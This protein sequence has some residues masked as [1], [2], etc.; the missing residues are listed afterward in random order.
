MHALIHYFVCTGDDCAVDCSILG[1]LATTFTTL[2]NTYILTYLLTYLLD[3]GS[4]M[5]SES[6]G[7]QI[8]Q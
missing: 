5:L 6:D 2:I 7:S 8:C 3:T 1:A 4:P